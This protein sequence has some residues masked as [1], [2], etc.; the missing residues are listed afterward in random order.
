MALP[1]MSD[2]ELSGLC[3]RISCTLLVVVKDLVFHELGKISKTSKKIRQMASIIQSLVDILPGSASEIS[4]G[5]VSKGHTIY[6][7]LVYLG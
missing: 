3:S 4:V 7:M 5:L 6:K 1:T 2:S